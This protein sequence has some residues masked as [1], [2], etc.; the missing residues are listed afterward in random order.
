M[1][2]RPAVI[3]L[4]ASLIVALGWLVGA[5]DGDQHII[6][7]RSE[8]EPQRAIEQK[9]PDTSGLDVIADAPWRVTRRPAGWIPV[10]IFV[11]DADLPDRGFRFEPNRFRGLRFSRISVYAGPDTIYEDTDTG[12]PV[13]GRELVI[14]NEL[15]ASTDGNLAGGPTAC[16]EEPPVECDVPKP[17][18]WHRI[19]RIPVSRFP[20][21]DVVHLKIEAVAHPVYNEK[22]TD[23]APVVFS[24]TLQVRIAPEALPS[25]G[26]AW[27]YYDAH[28][29]TVAEWSRARG[30]LAPRKAFGGPVQMIKESAFMMGLTESVE[31]D[32]FLDRVIVTDHNAFFSDDSMIG[33][34]PTSVEIPNFSWDRERFR[35]RN[36][37]IKHQHMQRLFGKSFGEEITLK[38]SYIKEG[39]NAG[40]HLL[41]LGAPHIDGPWHGG[42]LGFRIF[43]A[44]IGG[45]PNPNSVEATLLSAAKTESAFA[46]A[47]HPLAAGNN[48]NDEKLEFLHSRRRDFA[49][50][51]CGGTRTP[52]KFV[53]KGGQYWNEK[54]DL[55][56]AAE[57]G[58][59]GV[60]VRNV[61]FFD[62]HPFGQDT[63]RTPIPREPYFIPKAS[64]PRFAPSPLWDADLQNGL[65]DWH[66]RIRRL[67]YFSFDDRPDEV[68][69][70]KI[71]LIGGSDAHGD[72]NYTTVLLATA[73]DRDLF[74][75]FNISRRN[76][77]SNAF[78]R[79]R[80]YVDTTDKPGATAAE[81]ALNALAD[82]NAIATD[83]PVLTLAVDADIRFDGRSWNDGSKPTA[84]DSGRLRG[85]DEDGRMGGD[86][87]FDGGRTA[88]V[89]AGSRHS[90]LKYRWNNSNDFG[91]AFGGLSNVVVY[92]DTSSNGEP[93]TIQELRPGAGG[94]QMTVLAPF[95]ALGPH[96]LNTRN[97]ELFV[98]F[99]DVGI[100][101]DAPTALSLG[102]FSGSGEAE[103]YRAYTNPVWVM[104][105]QIDAAGNSGPTAARQTLTITYTFGM[106]M[107]AEAYEVV[108]LRIGP[109]GRSDGR[110][111]RLTA[112]SRAGDKGWSAQTLG[113][114]TIKNAVYRVTNTDEDIRIDTTSQGR[115]VAILVEP[116][117]LHGNRLNSLAHEVR[118]GMGR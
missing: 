45:E 84:D 27:R 56:L 105:V 98:R 22:V 68:F 87:V 80:T 57:T 110:P 21:R 17:G 117:D 1:P 90:A 32:G 31:A 18:G 6:D 69:P 94:R 72:F 33:G 4:V 51:G 95:K 115:F 92:V 114:R 37:Q 25:L 14:V 58:G 81:R 101:F 79:V 65:L 74:R 93:A 36:G 53:L 61:D 40:S 3:G 86:G 82:G 43:G 46:Y 85:F 16:A 39:V 75:R 104:P 107:A 111:I 34:G 109:D 55:E 30:L 20:T 106:S 113:G 102:A 48:W 10:M 50:K 12:P 88:L 83:G 44:T 26:V 42:G 19:I 76:V 11:P 35:N 60:R 73:L 108:L 41:L 63:S 99:E 71:Y 13:R 78:G 100:V 103:R 112:D 24:R 49:R 62:L 97:R 9:Y 64:Y 47:A 29:H 96:D 52:C 91:A 89:V 2:R 28:M 23:A 116:R 70:R 77:T 59:A 8:D 7:V 5:D 67:F 54:N 38:T 118:I 66:R 15:G